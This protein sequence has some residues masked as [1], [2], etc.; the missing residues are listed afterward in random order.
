MTRLK[1]VIVVIL[2][3][4]FFLV[5]FDQWLPLRGQAEAAG[6]QQ[7]IGMM[8]AVL[9]HRV[10]T[11]V[12]RD[13]MD[14]LPALDNSNPVNLLLDPPRGYV[15]VHDPLDPATLEPGSWAFDASRGVLVYRVRYDEYFDGS[16]MDPPRGEWRVIVHYAGAREPGNIRSVLLTPLAETSWRF[17]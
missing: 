8:Q 12:I 2:I 3:L 13:G 9:G 5:A 1:F 6:V 16:L 7:T 15:G 11:Q 4:L 14:T 10:A 17:E